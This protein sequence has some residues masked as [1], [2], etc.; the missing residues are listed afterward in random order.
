MLIRFHFSQ[1]LTSVII[2]YLLHIG[3]QRWIRPLVDLL[4]VHRHI[5]LLKKLHDHQT[6]TQ[7]PV[8]SETVRKNQHAIHE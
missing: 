4:P 1:K 2:L 7:V 5:N 6:I 3:P 8:R